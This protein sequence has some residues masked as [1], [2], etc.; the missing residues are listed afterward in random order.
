M[1][2][3]NGVT[4]AAYG[5]YKCLN[6][7][8]H[9]YS[10]KA[11]RD[12]GQKCQSCDEDIKPYKLWPLGRYNCFVCQRSW[13]TKFDENGCLCEKCGKKV[14]QFLIFSLLNLLF[15]YITNTY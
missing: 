15:W 10:S 4:H 14:C 12:W 11:W 13:K 8:R 9:W 1:S 2:Y 3:T 6:C 5:E 7:N